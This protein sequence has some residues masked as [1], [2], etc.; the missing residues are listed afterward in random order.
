MGDAQLGT[1][2]VFLHCPK[3]HRTR[4][5]RRPFADDRS[6]KE[7]G[8][9]ALWMSME[10][11]QLQDAFPADSQSLRPEGAIRS[12]SHSPE[13]H[14]W[15]RSCPVLAMFWLLACLLVPALFIYTHL[16]IISHHAECYQ[17]QNWS[18][19][20][21]LAGA[22]SLQMATGVQGHTRCPESPLAP[23]QIRATWSP[24]SATGTPTSAALPRVPV[25]FFTA[26]GRT[27]NGSAACKQ[28]YQRCLRV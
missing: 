28:G 10:M 13:P 18:Q 27:R 8:S 19:R 6:G 2:P 4:Q 22:T 5:R 25:K 17:A 15:L 1:S 26:Q 7:T 12:A 20:N 14:W 11:E 16:I 24:Q 3:P 21:R 23:P 9:L